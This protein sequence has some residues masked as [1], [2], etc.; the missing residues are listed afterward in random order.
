MDPRAPHVR[1]GPVPWIFFCEIAEPD[2]DGC[3]IDGS[4]VDEV[5]LVIPGGHRPVLAQSAEGALD[6]V[7]LL[8]GRRVESGR[9]A[10]LAAAA[11]PG[12]IWSAGSG[13]VALMPRLRRRERIA[14]LEYAL[15]ARTRPGL[16]RGRPGPRRAIARRP[17]SGMKAR[18]SWRCPALVTRASGRQPASASR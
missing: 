11:E 3:H 8:V 2:P 15:S 10:A 4:A 9:A 6:G 5:A 13:M 14:L 12:R 16:V 1:L 17:R 7:A 18:E